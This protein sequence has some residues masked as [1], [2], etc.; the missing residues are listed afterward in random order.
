LHR[1][2]EK[3]SGETKTVNLARPPVTGTSGAGNS[4]ENY[5]AETNSFLGKKRF[6]GKYDE[7]GAIEMPTAN[8]RV[9]G[10]SGSFSRKFA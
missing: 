2:H 6:Q 4:E 9:R 3:I 10:S 7:C 8:E 5:H 1:R